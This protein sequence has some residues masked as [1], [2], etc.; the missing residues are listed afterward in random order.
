MHKINHRST[1]K[2]TRTHTPL[3]PL[4]KQISRK[5]NPVQVSSNHKT[6]VYLETHFNTNLMAKRTKL[7]TSSVN[8]KNTKGLYEQTIEHTCSV[9]LVQDNGFSSITWIP[10]SICFRPL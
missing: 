6:R 10:P 5:L 3:T 7:L 1:N 4:Q 9:T 2:Q 8:C